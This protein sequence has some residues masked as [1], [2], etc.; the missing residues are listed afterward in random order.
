MNTTFEEMLS[1]T[2]REEMIFILAPDIEKWTGS[3]HEKVLR[4]AEIKKL[5]DII[6][7]L[8]QKG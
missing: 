3:V 8:P 1:Y 7:N 2:V 6:L 5:A 4:R